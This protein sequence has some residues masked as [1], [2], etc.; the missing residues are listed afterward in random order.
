[1]RDVRVWPLGPYSGVLSAVSS[2]YPVSTSTP[3]KNISPKVTSHIFSKPRHYVLAI[4]HIETIRVDV[5]V[6]IYALFAG[7]IMLSPPVFFYVIAMTRKMNT[8]TTE[9]IR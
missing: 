5:S 7:K 2:E 8:A 6:D 1:M 4:F 9:R 3:P